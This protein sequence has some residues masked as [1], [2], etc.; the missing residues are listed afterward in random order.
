MVIGEP[1]TF[2]IKQVCYLCL[3]HTD[4]MFGTVEV[5]PEDQDAD[6]QDTISQRA[7]AEIA[8]EMTLIGPARDVA[9]VTKK[10]PGLNNSTISYVRA[11][12]SDVFSGDGR[13][14][15]MEF[16]PKDLTV[17]SGDTVV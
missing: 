7:R 5:V 12:M 15:V 3:V 16:L 9:Q 13:A 6:S 11:G 1:S 14:Q 8:A 2:P 4:R 10:E 17:K